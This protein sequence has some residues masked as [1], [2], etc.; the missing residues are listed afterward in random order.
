MAPH[1]ELRLI[2]FYATD[3][4]TAQLDVWGFRFHDGATDIV[5]HADDFYIPAE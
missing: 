5:T 2:P 1:R 3:T 4:I